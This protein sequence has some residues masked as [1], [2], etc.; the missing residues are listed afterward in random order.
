VSLFFD[1]DRLAPGDLVFFNFPNGRGIYKPNASHVGIYYKG[2]RVIDTRSLDSPV[3][4]RDIE[5]ASTVGFG[6]VR[7]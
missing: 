7:A 3:A 1:S 6:R 5:W 2:G 4:I